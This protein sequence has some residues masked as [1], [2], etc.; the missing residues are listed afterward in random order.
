MSPYQEAG[1]SLSRVSIPLPVMGWRAA[2]GQRLAPGRHCT[3]GPSAEHRRRYK[4][5]GSQTAAQFPLGAPHGL[6]M[7]SKVA[8]GLG[9]PS[10]QGT[11]P[12]GSLEIPNHI[13][14]QKNLINN[15]LF[16]TPFQ[17]HNSALHQNF[18]KIASLIVE[19]LLIT[20]SKHLMS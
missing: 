15:L 2:S 14:S 20:I 13:H 11:N 9:E 18:V 8:L 4:R 16:K 5:P 1:G 19:K 7:I 17:Y 10:Q 12:E 6:S 3:L